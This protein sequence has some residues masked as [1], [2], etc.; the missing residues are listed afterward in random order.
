[1]G[2]AHVGREKF[3]WVELKKYFF[4]IVIVWV[5]AVYVKAVIEDGPRE[6]SDAELEIIKRNVAEAVVRS[7]NPIRV[8]QPT[9]SGYESVELIPYESA[10]ELLARNPDGFHFSYAGGEGALPTFFERWR[11][12]YA[13]WAVFRYDLHEADE[14]RKLLQSYTST[15]FPINRD[16]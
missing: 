9:E 5:G 16:L 13:G 3:W 15:S 1:M 12:E 14:G 4:L 6:F 8:S 11:Y 10:D 2:F 7:H